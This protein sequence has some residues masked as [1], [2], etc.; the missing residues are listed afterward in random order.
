MYVYVYIYRKEMYVHICVS[1]LY[2]YV[3]H[4]GVMTRP[5]CG[6]ECPRRRER[7]TLR[8]DVG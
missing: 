7:L 2:I 8:L 5:S 6:E 4:N 3:C 1:M